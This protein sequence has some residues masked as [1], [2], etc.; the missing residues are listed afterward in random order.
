MLVS[1][2]GIA[3]FFSFKLP[4]QKVGYHVLRKQKTDLIRALYVYKAPIVL[5]PPEE[6]TPLLESLKKANSCFEA[7]D[8]FSK[9]SEHY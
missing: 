6:H 4:N 2:G 5:H 7:G 8:S 1:L 9:S 3:N